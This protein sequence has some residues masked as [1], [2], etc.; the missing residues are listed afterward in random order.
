MFARCLFVLLAL[1]SV[2]FTAS[3][4]EIVLNPKSTVHLQSHADGTVHVL[5]PDVEAHNE[6]WHGW[7]SNFP[8]EQRCQ[9]AGSAPFADW[10]REH[11]Q[12][13]RC[14]KR[15]FMIIAPKLVDHLIRSG[16][17][18]SMTHDDLSLIAQR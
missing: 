10:M 5:C 7:L 2:G 16:H 17:S 4:S 8:K 14:D 1:F 6:F 9:L 12:T 13:I 11:Q 15:V 18:V 3:A